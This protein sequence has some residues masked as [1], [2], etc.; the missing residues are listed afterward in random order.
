MTPFPPRWRV[1]S[2]IREAAWVARCVGDAETTPL[3]E[4]DLNALA[5]YLQPLEFD[6]GAP[7]FRAGGRPEGV[8]IVRS[9]M[10]ELSAGSGP[11]KIVVQMLYPGNVD[12][13][14]QLILGMPLPYS[15][16]ATESSRC[17]FLT[18]DSFEAL[19]RDHPAVARRWLSSVAARVSRSQTRLMGLLGRSLEQQIARLLLDEQ[20]SGRVPLPQRTLAAMLGVQRPSLN[21]VLK[22]LERRGLLE[23]GYGRIEIT[24][25]AGLERLAQDRR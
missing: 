9:G 8:W 16:R 3:T 6:R 2:P 1:D 17:L 13:D 21:K 4:D 23:L 20:H 15:G 10:I 24:D 25:E 22:D 14:I 7:I 11:R 5:S 12:G 18:S 19:V